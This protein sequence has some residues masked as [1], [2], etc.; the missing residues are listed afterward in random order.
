MSRHDAVDWQQF[1]APSNRDFA[2]SPFASAHAGNCVLIT[3]AGG[4]IGSVL[5]SAL[6]RSGAR[7]ILL[8]SSE[9]NLFEIHSRFRHEAILGSVDDAGL[10]DSIVNRYR[11]DLIYHTAAF[12]Q[13]PLL[14]ANPIAA[15]RNNVLGTYALAQSAIRGGV[16][17]L[18]LISTD[19]AV[20]PRSILGASK[21]IAELIV[22]SLSTPACRMNAIRLC[23]VIG[24][25]GS[26]VPIFRRQIACGQPVTVTD[27]QAA[28][29]FLT[30]RQTVESILACGACS[31]NGKIL[32]PEVGEPV[33]I[34]ALA[35]FLRGTANVPIVFT[36]LR[37]GDKISEEMMF[38]NECR[39]RSID[40]PLHVVETHM[41]SRARLQSI[42][43][44]LM[45]RTSLRDGDGLMRA[46]I[47]AVPEYVPSAAAAV[48]S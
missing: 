7:L 30:E 40:G 32:L 11:P 17:K 15:V 34:A 2:N 3:G 5:V 38:T 35:A 46:L 43:E 48:G 21:R 36:G 44:E 42:L 6:S 18:I 10:M 45:L 20:N 31:E 4:S 24:S 14:E 23:N 25:S 9:N 33:L 41:L 13:V 39:R 29:W 47:S 16:P 26:V 8:D 28:R 22:V 27:P 19:K 1:L 12:K 37:P